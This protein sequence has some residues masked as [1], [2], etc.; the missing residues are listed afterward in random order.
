M[1]SIAADTNRPS[2]AFAHRRELVDQI[3]L[4]FARAGVEH[5]V[6][7]PAAVQ[8]F[9]AAVHVEELG[10]SYVRPESPVVVASVDA[11]NR[12]DWP[13]P[14]PELWQCDEAHHL[15]PGNKWGRMAARWPEAMGIGWTASPTRLDRQPLPFKRLAVGPCMRELI[16]AGWLADYRIYGLPQPIDMSNVRRTPGADFNAADLD[17]A[18]QASA[19]VGDVVAHYQRF[20]AGLAGVTFAV[21]VVMAERH[22]QAFI[23]AGVPAAVLH[24]KTSAADR[25]AIIRAFR[26]GAILQVCNV[27]V[28]GEGFD[29]PGIRCV[30]MARPSES[31][32]L[33][34]QQSGRPLRPADGKPFGLIL[35]HVGNVQRHGLPD[36]APLWSLDGSVR[37]QGATVP[38]RVC[39]ACFLAFEGYKTACPYC[40]WRPAPKPASCPEEVEGDLTL[41]DAQLLARLRGEIARRRGE[42]IFP[43]GLP[44]VARPRALRLWTARQ[45]AIAALQAEIDRWA[46][47]WRDA[48]GD[49]PPALYR[50]FWFTFGVD[51]LGASLLTGPQLAGLVERVAC[52][53]PPQA[54]SNRP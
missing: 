14:A 4:A 49:E 23:N 25:R 30:S 10:R 48:T 16:D 12:R 42:P 31:Y 22:A 40:G 19:I 37:R 39:Q 11:A 34:L 53:R 41:Y 33:Y 35:D 36:H 3:S 28:L 32:G 51:V 24:A 26:S 1:A 8:Q 2:V 27:D 5:H 9:C 54:A 50:R 21:N 46:G 6:L 47:R 29:M 7:A 17:A 20:A 45:E 43:A 15:Q 52:D 18:A 44:A 38:I 13:G